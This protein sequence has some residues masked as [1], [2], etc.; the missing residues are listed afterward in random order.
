MAGDNF[1]INQCVQNAGP[2]FA[3]T[4]FPPSAFLYDAAMAA[5][6]AFDF[7]VFQRFI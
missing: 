6:V 1:A 5:Q 7:L 2:V 4:A 3:N